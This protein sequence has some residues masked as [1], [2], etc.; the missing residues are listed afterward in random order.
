MLYEC[1]AVMA[2]QIASTHSDDLCS[3]R[4]SLASLSHLRLLPKISLALKLCFSI[5]LTH[6]VKDTLV[7]TAEDLL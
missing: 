2:Q 5:S 4:K 7:L 3:L 1:D 6:F